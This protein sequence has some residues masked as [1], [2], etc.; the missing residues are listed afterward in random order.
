MKQRVGF[1]DLSPSPRSALPPSLGP[2]LS[3]TF[4]CASPPLFFSFLSFF[5]VWPKSACMDA[6]AAAANVSETAVRQSRSAAKEVKTRHT[7]AATL[8]THPSPLKVFF[9]DLQK[10]Q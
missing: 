3:L 10:V 7:L 8:T 4:L 1:D 2:A 9:F 5:P 6:A